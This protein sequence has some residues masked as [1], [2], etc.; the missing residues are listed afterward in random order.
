[1]LDLLLAGGV[2][3]FLEDPG[4]LLGVPLIA[5]GVIGVLLL[6][7]PFG[8]ARPVEPG[9]GAGGGTEEGEADAQIDALE[10]GHPSPETYIK[11][12]LFLAIITAIEVGLYYIPGFADGALLGILLALSGLKFVVVVLWFM[13]LRFDS[14]LFSTLFTG[15]MV[16]VVMLM[17]VVLSTLGSSLV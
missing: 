17:I 16:L 12:G 15:G 7:A 6:L 13:H 3:G 8:R 2:K 4:N 9:A 5:L 1:M 14:R 10:E 11:V